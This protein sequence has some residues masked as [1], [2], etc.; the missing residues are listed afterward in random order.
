MEPKIAPATPLTKPQRSSGRPVVVVGALAVLVLLVSGCGTVS[1]TASTMDDS[2]ASPTSGRPSADVRR[3]PVEPTTP[4]PTPTASLV[5]PV[6]EAGAI[7]SRAGKG[8]DPRLKPGG[9]RVS[10]SGSGD[11]LIHN[12]LSDQ[13][14]SAGSAGSYDFAPML[15]GAKA[16]VSEA[17]LGICHLE[18][19][20]SDPAVV[21]EFPHLYVRPEL[22]RGIKAT[23]FDQCS[24]ASNWSLDKGSEGIRRTLDALDDAKVGHAGMAR[25]EAEALTPRIKLV[26]GVPIAHLAYSWDFNGM[27][28]PTERSWEVNVI[29]PA[30]V[31]ADARAARKA[32]A[33]IVIASLHMGDPDSHTVSGYQRSV[34]ERVTASGQVDLILGHNS[35]QVQPIELVNGVWVAYGHGNLLS[36]QFDDWVRNREGIITR[37]DFAE[38]MDRRFAVVIATAFPIL[39]TSSPHTIHD[40]VAKWPKSAP[41]TRWVQAYDRTRQTVLAGGGAAHGLVVAAHR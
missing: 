30:K 18:T 16:R 1:I 33:R 12:S 8:V 17:D 37:F 5:S 40:L 36:G 2:A 24:T 14:R 13:A 28:P 31:I 6:P 35:H 39:D 11:I 15:S 29:D 27:R 23:G 20:F 9:K 3:A 19:P 7:R 22:A 4:A 10:V 25:T 34:A 21:T 41:P 38:R 32:G 26:K